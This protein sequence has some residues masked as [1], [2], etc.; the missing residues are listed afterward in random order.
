MTFA[1]PNLSTIAAVSLVAGCLRLAS[2]RQPSDAAPPSNPLSGPTVREPGLP[3][4]STTF[5]GRGRREG[6]R[7]IDHRTFLKGL[8]SLRGESA[9]SNVR[10]SREQEETLLGIEREFRVATRTYFDKNLNDIRD[11][12]DV[13][14]IRG[15][16]PATES[17]IRKGMDELRKNIVGNEI[18]TEQPMSD[19]AVKDAAREK[20]R[21]IY[22]GAPRA[23]DIHTR[24]WRLLNPPQREA[25][26]EVLDALAASQEAQRRAFLSPSA[27]TDMMGSASP[28]GMAGMS[29]AMKGQTGD[30]MMGEGMRS[31]AKTNADRKA[32]ERAKSNTLRVENDPAELL[33]VDP[34]TIAANDPRLPERV[35][36]RIYNMKPEARIE[37]IGRYLADLKAELAEAKNAAGL[38]KT[39]VPTVDRVNVPTPEKK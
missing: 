17:A 3:G 23:T 39:A 19:A 21:R 28:N 15:D 31:E 5:T 25:L 9:A 16:Q 14:G 13:L 36:R 33:G 18:E 24:I 7:V 34:A 35:R 37:A 38:D 11:V 26:S 20:A 1:R 6:E 10:L 30:G 4:N 22:D 29:D 12:R 32:A 2:A 8:E 27:M